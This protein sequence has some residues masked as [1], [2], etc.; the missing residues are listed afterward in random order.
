MEKREKMGQKVHFDVVVCEYV[1][2]KSTKKTL[3][4]S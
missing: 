4:Y 1:M 3:Q 2:L